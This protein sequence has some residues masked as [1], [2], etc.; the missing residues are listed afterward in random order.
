[1]IAI[2][3]H[4][5]NEVSLKDKQESGAT[6]ETRV[7]ILIAFFNHSCLQLPHGFMTIG[8]QVFHFLNN[9][10]CKMVELKAFAI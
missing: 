7:D 2:H 5:T 4:T 6:T 9:D 8:F 3:A 1:M 10:I